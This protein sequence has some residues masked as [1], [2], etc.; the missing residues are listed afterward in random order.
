MS[1]YQY[2]EFQAIDRPLTKKEMDDL[3]SHS[4]RAR[5]TPTSFVNDYAWGSFKGNEDAW[6]ERYFD[7]FL[8]LANWG[9]HVLKLRVPD[10][11]LDPKIARQY[12]SGESA[13]V[14]ELNGQV[15]MS[16][17][18]EDEEGGE[19][20]EGEGQLSSLISVRTELSRGDLRALYLGWLLCA[21]R[22]GLGDDAI[23]PPVPPGLGELSACL[24]AMVG[25]LRIDED[26]I[27]VAAQESRPL[28][29][30]RPAAEDVLSWVSRLPQAEKDQVL[31]QWIIDE[32]AAAPV[33]LRRRFLRDH[34]QPN[35]D[36]QRRRTVG[37]LLRAA[38]RHAEQRRKIAAEK[39][40]EDK[41]RREREVAAAR[42]KYLDEIAPRATQLWG[43]VESLVATKQ[44]K[45]YERAIALLV[46]LRDL[47]A[48]NSG[49]EFRRRLEEVRT[50]NAR[51]PAFLERL[52]G[53]G[54]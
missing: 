14:W 44:A 40:T 22:E 49:F 46:D 19:W 42:S 39:A 48:R 1:E 3:R 25:F 45:S 26:L 43:E 12:L 34:S 9:T 24:E 4:T 52:R 5:I 32:E 38:E 27:H 10:R 33:N 29:T 36:V 16:F 51:R 28:A 13:S 20:V 54:L 41:A 18:S 47:S 31:T 15:V 8:Y 35:A 11:L 37:E 50:A 6:M 17:V 53:A 30:A 23:E 21:Q 2:Y 7:A